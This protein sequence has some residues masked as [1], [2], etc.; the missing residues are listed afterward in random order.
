MHRGPP[1]LHCAQKGSPACVFPF[2]PPGEL[3]LTQAMPLQG[4]SSW[5]VV[6][7]GILSLLKAQIISRFGLQIL[8]V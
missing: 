1:H 4:G 2:L 6:V 3:V 8:Q 7:I 5:N